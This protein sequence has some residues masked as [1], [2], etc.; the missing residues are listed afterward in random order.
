MRMRNPLR[1]SFLK[2]IALTLIGIPLL[3]TGCLRGKKPEGKTVKSEIHLSYSTP[4]LG[5]DWDG[6]Q[7]LE[8]TKIE[9]E[10]DNPVSATP[11]DS[12]I[13]QLKMALSAA[14]AQDLRDFII[15]NADAFFSLESEY[16]ALEKER[17]YPFTLE[18][19]CKG[20]R[21]LVLYR[22]NPS[23]AGPPEIFSDF[24]K[25]ILEVLKP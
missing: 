2:I 9:Y 12:S 3:T 14:E 16:G 7:S 25:K 8:L 19:D 18:I 15:N 6:G 17:H 20:K 1:A 10:Y 21:K 22:S 13:S 23:F 5:V 4:W 24:E 11:S